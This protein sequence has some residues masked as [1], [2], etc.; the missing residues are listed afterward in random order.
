MEIKE[1]GKIMRDKIQKILGELPSHAQSSDKENES[2]LV[3]ANI[4]YESLENTES[5]SGSVSTRKIVDILSMIESHNKSRISPWSTSMD[6]GNLSKVELL[7]KL[8]T[9]QFEL[10]QKES[11]ITN[12]SQQLESLRQ[13]GSRAVEQLESKHA[14]ALRTLE[15][16]LTASLDKKLELIEKL[17]R[18]KAVI[19]RRVEDLTMDKKG[20]E[21]KLNAKLERNDDLMRRE[22]VREKES[23]LS[24]EKANRAKWE[25]RRLAEIKEQTIK[26]LEPEIE[27][28]LSVHR[29]EKKVMEMKH[30][31]ELEK[32]RVEL[33]SKFQEEMRV[34]RETAASEVREA[35]EKERAGFRKLE[36][37]R[38]NSFIAELDA[39]RRKRIEELNVVRNETER[40]I[41]RERRSHLEEVS[42]LKEQ[43]EVI[44]N[45]TVA[46]KVES[47]I[48]LVRSK[49]I[50]EM[51]EE[52]RRWRAEIS[53][54]KEQQ[55]EDILDKLSTENM[56][57]VEKAKIE[58]RKKHERFLEEREGDV[59]EL[60][61]ELLQARKAYQD[62]M[63]KIQSEELKVEQL[64]NDV[65]VKNE[66]LF[67]TAQRVSQIQAEA[68]QVKFEKL[69]LINQL[70]IADN[71]LESFKASELGKI[72][73]RVQSL[74]G[75]KDKE[76]DQL[77][78][79]VAYLEAK[80]TAL[81]EAWAKTRN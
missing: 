63:E 56:K 78:E 77:N 32:Q 48:Q 76:I 14:S 57:M 18:E 65:R 26:S 27:K 40:I 29:Q 55:I 22:L 23:F 16:G 60:E 34:V 12:L 73:S 67:Q 62:C 74:I 33:T 31:E 25:Q 1:S 52:Q 24:V 69:N 36:S 70:K 11:Q 2:P 61:K 7:A 50:T 19:T 21:S 37:E 13:E 20:L 53:A 30:S 51:E 42:K 80:N 10:G 49:L 58:E 46:E 44:L 28:I 79:R 54:E 72:E 38:F 45:S 4:S 39:E 81:S 8:E 6:T 41:E 71:S 43:A 75:C 5:K 17:L 3:D 59:A 35:T 47:Q 66:E 64:R 15:E 68:D 9:A